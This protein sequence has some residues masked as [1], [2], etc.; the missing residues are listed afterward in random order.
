MQ[1][2]QAW[3]LR[4]RLPHAVYDGC[5]E[6]INQMEASCSQRRHNFRVEEWG[7]LDNP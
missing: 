3:L 2:V 5:L 7:H 6:L 4:Y 1:S